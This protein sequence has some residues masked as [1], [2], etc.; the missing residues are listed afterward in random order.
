VKCQEEFVNL[1]M[2]MEARNIA[3]RYAICFCVKLDDNVTTT[4]GKI[5]QAFGND[6]M[7]RAQD[8]PWH[9]I[10][11]EGRNLIEDEQRSSR[12]SAT[13]TGDNTARV[14]ELVRSDGTLTVKMIA[15]EVNM[16]RETFRL[17]LTEELRLRQICDKMEPR[18]LTAQQRDAR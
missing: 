6:E 8:F 14:R 2:E 13:R 17:I 18:N 15:D 1:V 12:P 10:S 11:S 9:K 5:Q 4:H 3:Q 7:S 16:N